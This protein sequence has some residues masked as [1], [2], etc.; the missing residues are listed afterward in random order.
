MYFE[1]LGLDL[2]AD[3]GAF[4]NA[5]LSLGAK[6]LAVAL[7]TD[8]IPLCACLADILDFKID[9]K[10]KAPMQQAYEAAEADC[11]PDCSSEASCSLQ[12]HRSSPATPQ[13]PPNPSFS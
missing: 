12:R 13:D 11:I 5:T 1:P 10:A 8:S 3:A 4:S 2:Q 7:A 9:C 6:T